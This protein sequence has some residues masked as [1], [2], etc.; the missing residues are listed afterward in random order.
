MPLTLTD[1]TPAEPPNTGTRSGATLG[2]RRVRSAAGWSLECHRRPP[3]LAYGPAKVW[4]MS[5]EIARRP[6]RRAALEPGPADWPEPTSRARR[7]GLVSGQARNGAWSGRQ[8]SNRRHSPWKAGLQWRSH[9]DPDEHGCKR[10]R[11]RI[12][13]CDDDT[14]LQAGNSVRDRVSGADRL[15]ADRIQRDREGELV[16]ARVSLGEGVVVR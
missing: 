4:P 8:A 13:S 10:P 12:R 15:P 2:L 3:R 6:R 14:R 1:E 11:R 16:D 5:G 7:T 9:G